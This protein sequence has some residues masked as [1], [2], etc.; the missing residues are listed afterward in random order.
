MSWL[1]VNDHVLATIEVA[2]S[3]KARLVGVLGRT[4]LEGALLIK[5]TCSVHT[6]GV[7]FP[8][9]VAYCDGDLTV[10]DIVTMPPN[11]IGLPRLRARQVIEA[12]KGSFER[13]QVR[14]GDQLEIVYD[15]PDGAGE[16]G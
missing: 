5:P 13:W 11:R 3:W 16:S 8:L 9:D 10:I 6:I 14:A 15:R 4:E 1:V 2:D 12:S 7:P